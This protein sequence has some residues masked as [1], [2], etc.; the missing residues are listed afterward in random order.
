MRGSSACRC[1]TTAKGLDDE[2]IRRQQA[3]GHFG[4][5]G[6]R[7]R[8]AIVRGRLEVRT[9]LGSGTEIDLTIPSAIAYP[10]TTRRLWWQRLSA[11]F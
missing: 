11:R 4:L 2:T 6:M 8:A 9:A 3:G 10:A 5:P 7:E 1:S